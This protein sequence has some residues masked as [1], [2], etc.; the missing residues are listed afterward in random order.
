MLEGVQGNDSG[1]NLQEFYCRP[2]ARFRIKL[3]ILARSDSD[4]DKSL[5]EVQYTL[6]Q[7]ENGHEKIF[8]RPWFKVKPGKPAEISVSKSKSEIEYKVGILLTE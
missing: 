2:K 8:G 4:S 5:V 3:D 1:F 6:K 7:I